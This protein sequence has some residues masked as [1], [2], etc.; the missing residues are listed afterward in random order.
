MQGAVYSKPVT[1]SLQTVA[2]GL[3]HPGRVRARNED[4]WSYAAEAGV[5]A[6]CDGIGG[7]PGGEIASQIAAEAFVEMLAGVPAVER[8]PK[9]IAQ[10][11]CAANR[12]VH[13]RAAH[14]P[15][16]DGM[17]TTLVGLALRGI[18]GKGGQREAVL[19]HVGDSRAYRWRRGQLL[20][21]TEDHSLVAEQM[22]MGVLTGEEATRSPMRHVITRSVG[23][24]RSVQPEVQVLPAEPGDLLLLC[25]DGLTRELPDAA[26]AVLLG[27]A[28]TLTGRAQSLVDAAL[29]TGGRDNVTVLLVEVAE[30]GGKAA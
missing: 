8:T 23:T 11:V 10:A 22:R 26:L 28:G 13:A 20:C 29:R 4:A 6:V 25:T 2:A 14:E 15:Q 30:I 17:G 3:S 24:R 21:L 18:A 16:L 27:R 7:A 1:A 19:V 9:S 12:R 5:F